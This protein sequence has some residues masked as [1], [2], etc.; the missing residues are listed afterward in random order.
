MGGLTASQR[1]PLPPIPGWVGTTGDVDPAG[2]ASVLPEQ[3]VEGAVGGDPAEPFPS[4]GEG[5][6]MEV[7]RL[8]RQ[9]LATRHTTHQGVEPGATIAGADRD[10]LASVLTEW[11]QHL[12]AEGDEIRNQSLGDMVV[13]AQGLGRMGTGKFR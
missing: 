4:L 13:N 3:L 1:Q 7:G 2:G 11:L 5:G 12:L 6:E 9:V 8:T 10:G